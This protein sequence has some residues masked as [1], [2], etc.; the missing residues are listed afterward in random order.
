M[1]TLYWMSFM[2][3][4]LILMLLIIRSLSFGKV[5]TKVFVVFWCA[6]LIRLLLPFSFQIWFTF[7][8]LLSGV[9]SQKVSISSPDVEKVSPVQPY[10]VELRN[11]ETYSPIPTSTTEVYK[12]ANS[13]DWLTLIW[14][15][16]FVLL[17]IYFS[18]AIFMHYK[19]FRIAEKIH[20]PEVLSMVNRLLGQ[21]K[22]NVSVKQADFISSPLAYGFFHP[23]IVLP[24]YL[25]RS[26]EQMNLEFILRHE[27]THIKRFD[28]VLKSILALTLCVHW[29]NPLVWVMY[30]I[31]TRDIEI[32][33]DEKVIQLTGMKQKSSYARML[34]RIEEERS[35]FRKNPLVN[36]FGKNATEERIIFMMKSNK[37]SKLFNV[38]VVSLIAVIVI[39]TSGFNKIKA[40][41]IN[42]QVDVAAVAPIDI[43]AQDDNSTIVYGFYPLDKETKTVM[44]II[45]PD[46]GTTWYENDYLDE[47]TGLLHHFDAPS[48]LAA[49]SPNNSEK[50]YDSYF[51]SDEDGSITCVSSNYDSK[52]TDIARSIDN[53]KTWDYE[54]DS[55]EWYTNDEYIQ[56][57]ENRIGYIDNCIAN[58]EPYY[59]EDGK[60]VYLS[61]EEA[62]NLTDEIKK[63]I[64]EYKNNN[65]FVSTDDT[66]QMGIPEEEYENA[67]KGEK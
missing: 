62:E 2:G 47:T 56:E 30:F 33:C 25:L 22:R 60:E 39:F 1:N 31:A 63:M 12:Q 27:M 6:I 19:R 58:N 48:S 13:F 66:H 16:G 29:F 10:D 45:S 55:S 32:S 21:S 28:I 15:C 50:W 40:I 65:Y 36:Y 49:V 64:T 4:I 26:E 8:N 18:I 9:F 61:K 3:S 38:A 20:D 52:D 44:S 41:G 43:L 5:K 46:G 59:E 14:G 34:L 51:I 37:K 23:V 24:L 42:K 57:L 35:E 17:L 53:G 54:S 11:A 67:M 7:G